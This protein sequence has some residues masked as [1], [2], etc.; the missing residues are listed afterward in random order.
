M[1]SDKEA[2]RKAA[3]ERRRGIPADTR[4]EWEAA[5]RERVR[6]ILDQSGADTLLSYISTPEEVDT[7]VL[8]QEWL[9]AGKMVFTPAVADAGTLEWRPLTRLDDLTPGAYGI[10]EPP[11]PTEPCP[12]DPHAPV[13][14]PCLAFNTKCHR[15]GY[16]GGHFDRFLAD[17]QGPSIGL[18]FHCQHAYFTPEPHDSLL[19]VVLTEKMLMDRNSWSQI[20]I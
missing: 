4:S 19:D 12:I 2:V 17:H 16:G 20:D 1:S 9:D 18:A 10:P 14:V 7:R 11:P 3:R 15:I 6:K 5:I 8:L 13:L